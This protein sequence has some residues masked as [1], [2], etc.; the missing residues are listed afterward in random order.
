MKKIL[1]ALAAVA[2]LAACSKSE[3][4][5][6]PADEI[7]L[8]VVPQNMTKAMLTGET[9]LTTEQF[10]VWAWYKQLPA[11][12][13]IAKWME[14]AT[15]NQLYIPEKPF[16]YRQSTSWG[17]VTPYYWPKLGSL[18]FAGY[19]PTDIA[20]SVDYTFDGSNNKMIFKNIQQ[21]QV[22]ATA[23]EYTEDIMYFNMTPSSVDANPVTVVFKHALSWITVNVKKS[24]G[25]PKII[26]DEINFTDVNN[27][28][29]GTVNGANVIEWKLTGEAKTTPVGTAVELDETA[30]KLKEPLFIPQTMKGNLVIKYT[31]YSSDTEKFTEV[32]TKAL[33]EL[34]TGLNTWEPAKH[35]IYNV[36]IGTSEIL[37]DPS[38]TDWD[39]VEV[40]VEVNKTPANDSNIEGSVSDSDDTEY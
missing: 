33:D 26:I 15:N 10:N 12:T 30:T 37:I 27:E 20:E 2:T 23:D 17:G 7:S 29:E 4:A 14:D 24:A 3:V 5:Y 38:V 39:E 40:P 8:S 34:K 11:S 18:L 9:F 36:E 25:S 19:Y 13:P 31:V 1:F 6:E 35:Y 28:G 16:T 21:G 32:Y 22:S